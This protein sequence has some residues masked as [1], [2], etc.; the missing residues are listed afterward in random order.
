LHTKPG[1]RNEA[2]ASWQIIDIQLPDKNQSVTPG[3]D[4]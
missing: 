1:A 4:V 3:S 2:P